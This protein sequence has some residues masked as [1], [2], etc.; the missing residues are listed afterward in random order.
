MGVHNNAQSARLHSG[1]NSLFTLTELRITDSQVH[2]PSGDVYSSSL[3][4]LCVLELSRLR[5]PSHENLVDLARLV[6]ICELSI[7]DRQTCCLPDELSHLT[8][9]RR[10]TLNCPS[11]GC[12]PSF[13]SVMTHLTCLKLNVMGTRLDPHLCRLE[14]LLGTFSPLLKLRTLYIRQPAFRLRPFHDTVH[15]QALV[16]AVCALGKCISILYAD[17]RRLERPLD[18]LKFTF[19]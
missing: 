1:I 5:T 4:N 13:I 12:V 11:V 18:T 19:Y 14:S 17:G 16:D 8:C 2:W 7:A 15:Q 9:L 10:L 6:R 3:T